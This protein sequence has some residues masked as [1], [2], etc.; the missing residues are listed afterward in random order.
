VSSSAD[1]HCKL[2]IQVVSIALT[3][4]VVEVV[5]SFSTYDDKL[6]NSFFRAHQALHENR[7]SEAKILLTRCIAK[8]PGFSDAYL[9]RAMVNEKLGDYVSAIKDASASITSDPRHWALGNDLQVSPYLCRARL[10]M[11]AGNTKLAMQDYQTAANI[12]SKLIK[13]SPR[14][15]RNYVLRANIYEILGRQDLAQADLTLADSLRGL[16]LSSRYTEGHY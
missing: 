8:S 11:K 7:Y 12:F 6:L 2:T 13:E 16:M 3:I 1:N 5:R 15:D 10:Y 4:A 14:V 9:S